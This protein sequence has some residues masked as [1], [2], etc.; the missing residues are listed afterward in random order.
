MSNPISLKQAE[1]R[2]FSTAANDGT[3][4]ILLGCFFLMFALAPLL[5]VRLGDFWS[6]AIFLP[7]LGAAYLLLRFV[8]RAI[9]RPRI[10][11]VRFGEQRRARL[12]RFNLVLLVVNVFALLLGILAAVFYRR[13]PGELLSLALGLSLLAGFSFAGFQ[14]GLTRLYLYGLLSTAAPLLGE[15]LWSRGLVSHHGIPLVFGTLAAIMIV[16]GLVLLARLLRRYPDPEGE[17][18]KGA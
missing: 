10:G 18:P 15:L 13:V 16:T 6:S 9:I 3:W 1:Q 14:L 12:V 2:V 4:D 8:R 5:S 11:Q 7:I 17:A